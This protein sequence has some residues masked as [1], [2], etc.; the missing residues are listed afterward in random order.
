M[1]AMANKRHVGEHVFMCPRG[2]SH[3]SS[4]LE[5]TQ[6]SPTKEWKTWDILP[7]MKYFTTVRPNYCY[8]QARRTIQTLN[9][10][11]EVTKKR[12]H[13]LWSIYMR[14]SA[15]RKLTNQRWWKSKQRSAQGGEGGV[16]T[17]RTRRPSG[18]DEAVLCLHLGGGYLFID[19]SWKWQERSTHQQKTHSADIPFQIALLWSLQ[20]PVRGLR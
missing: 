17:G 12:V 16:M 1:S 5:M 9:W 11:N 4:N 8:M 19:L 6:C 18:V 10:G 15:V 7:T 20:L 2:F 3:N 14:G 13:A